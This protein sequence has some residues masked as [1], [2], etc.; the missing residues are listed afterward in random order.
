[1][2]EGGGQ[3]LRNTLAYSAILHFPVRVVKIR[4]KRQN[5]GLAAQH[6]ECFKLVCDA[7]S[8]KMAGDRLKSSEVTF[9]PSRLREGSFSADPKTAGAVTLMV[10]ASLLPLV[11]AGGLS[12]LDL[13]GGTDVDFSPPLDFLQ[14][15]LAPT[16]KRM[17]VEA[18]ISCERRG[19]YPKGGGRVQ[20]YVSGL[21][22][23]LKPIV[24]DKRGNVT[25]VHVLCYAT[26]A[27]GW[28]DPE[29]VQ[30]TEEEFGP[31]LASELADRGA[32]APKALVQCDA[33]RAGDPHTS[34]AGCQILVETS[35]G[36][37][38]HGSAAPADLKKWA[39]LY[40]VW[41]AAAE[42]ALGAL[43][44]QLGSGAAADEHLVDQLI[45]PASLAKGTSRI[46]AGRELSLHARTAVHIAEA[47]VPGV[48]FRT[49]HPEPHLTLLECDG[50]GRCPGDPPLE[51]RGAA[52]PGDELVLRL[53]PGSLSG[54][55]PA[56]LADFQNDMRRLGE[57]KQVHVT[58]H[59]K[60][61]QISVANV[62][63][64]R[65]AGDC[66]AQLDLILR[67]YCLEA[68]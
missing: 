43:K 23:A 34:K 40:E 5:P 10:Q 12:E 55:G 46:L 68:L 20:I 30:R 13:A 39:S 3:I 60:Q 65:K 6:L 67:F 53:V 50:I 33:D 66:R 36:G 44:A 61:D 11:F 38:F 4:A 15:A 2:M 59:A 52:G 25:R 56:M 18:D 48:R 7:C 32:P 27:D 28:L 57:D 37:L 41:G 35:G 14:R 8:A 26:P 64:A 49:T 47:L 42:Q 45:L 17:G 51:V 31:W 24:L 1:V 29:E 16:L 54:A 58:V 62:G 21:K 63:D 22:G 19:F 9:T